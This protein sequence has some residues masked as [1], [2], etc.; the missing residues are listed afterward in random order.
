MMNPMWLSG[1]DVLDIDVQ[2]AVNAKHRS[3]Q[4][5]RLVRAVGRD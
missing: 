3:V 2:R 5:L 4:R 1:L